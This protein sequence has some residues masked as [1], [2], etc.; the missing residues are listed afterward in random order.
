MSP[1][2]GRCHAQR[3]ATLTS[4]SCPSHPFLKLEAKPQEVCGQLKVA[5]M[6]SAADGFVDPRLQTADQIVRIYRSFE[7]REPHTD[8]FDLSQP[9][10]LETCRPQISSIG[11]RSRSRRNFAPAPRTSGPPASR[12]PCQSSHGPSFSGFATSGCGGEDPNATGGVW[13]LRPKRDGL[14]SHRLP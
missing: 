6:I 11:L 3:S 1:S 9:F 7:V 13:N 14:Y 12:P 10:P 2:F 5:P 4:L 8:Q